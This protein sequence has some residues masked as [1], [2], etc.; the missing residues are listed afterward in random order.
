MIPVTIPRILWTMTIITLG[1]VV[2]GGEAMV[3]YLFF[4]EN[5]ELLF[6]G[7][8]PADIFIGLAGLVAM[9]VYGKDMY[10]LRR[11]MLMITRKKNDD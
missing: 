2:F 1:G 6:T 10:H 7:S 3:L 4:V 8:L 11:A 5:S 9:V